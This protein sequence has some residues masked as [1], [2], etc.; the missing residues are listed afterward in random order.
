MA[1][2]SKRRATPKNKFDFAWACDT[3]DNGRD[4]A[5]LPIVQSPRQSEVDVTRVDELA[6]IFTER[7]AR[8]FWNEKLMRH[9]FPVAKL[10]NG[11]LILQVATGQHVGRIFE[12]DHEAYCGYVELLADDDLAQAEEEFEGTLDELG[13]SGL[14]SPLATEDFLAILVHPQSDCAQW[15]APDFQ[16]FYAAVAE[17]WSELGQSYALRSYLEGKP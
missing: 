6:E 3:I 15:I 17:Y 7:R 1:M 5:R 2:G 8:S 14:A 16:S 12:S 10:A 4:L 9:A 13:L 11:D